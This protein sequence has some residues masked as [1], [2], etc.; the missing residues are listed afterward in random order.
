MDEHRVAR[1]AQVTKIVNSFKDKFNDVPVI[2]AGDLNDKPWTE[3]IQKMQE[4][5]IDLYSLKN[6]QHMEDISTV[7]SK[8]HEFPDF[9]LIC[10]IRKAKV[11]PTPDHRCLD[12]MFVKQNDFFKQNQ[13]LVEKYLELPGRQYLPPEGQVATLAI[14]GPEEPSDHFSMVYDLNIVYD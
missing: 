10:D 2:V 7:K 6:I 13:I 12:Y 11:G 8:D 9:T 1:T 5:Y 3:P 14:P 4:S